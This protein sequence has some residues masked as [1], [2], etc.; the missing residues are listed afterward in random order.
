MKNIEGLKDF[1]IPPDFNIKHRAGFGAMMRLR[2]EAE[3]IVPCL[4][5]VRDCFDEIVVILNRST[6][7]TREMIEALRLPNCRIYEYPFE[8][9]FRGPAHAAVPPASVRHSAFFYNWCLSKLRCTW[10]A[11]WDGDNV[12]LLHFRDTLDLIRLNTCDVIENC[13]WDM[14]GPRADM[15]GAQKRVSHEGRVFRVGLGVHYTPSGNGFTQALRYPQ[16]YRHIRQED[17]TF[18]HLKWCKRDPTC[19]WP[20]NW[21]DLPHFRAIANRHLPRHKYTGPRP[22]VLLDYLAVD[23]D[24][25]ALI[26]MYAD[27]RR[28]PLKCV[29]QEE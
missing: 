1:D 27:G 19:Y 8:I 13:A 2:D 28:D 20:Q 10:V 12:A 3:W 5:A 24:P 22:Q 25:V 9:A 29:C 11:K 4:L 16:R 6:D 15:L 23:K 17:P 14:V 21:R 7:N 26:G 18:L